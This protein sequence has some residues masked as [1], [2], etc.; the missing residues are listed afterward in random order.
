MRK[1]GQRNTRME[2]VSGPSFS[3][4]ARRWRVP[5]NKVINF[6]IEE[7]PIRSRIFTRAQGRRVW[8]CAVD[9]N[10]HQTVSPSMVDARARGS[11]GLSRQWN[12]RPRGSRA[13]E[14]LDSYDSG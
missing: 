14:Q 2:A 10:G 8:S 4:N 11:V 5:I 13:A 6:S 12:N 3:R 1:H 7:R 9:V